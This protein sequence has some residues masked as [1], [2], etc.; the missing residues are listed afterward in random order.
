MDDLTLLEVLHA[1]ATAIADAL[2]ELEDWGLAGTTADQYR[3]DL[4]ACGPVALAG[5]NG[6]A[7]R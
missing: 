2:S 5:R 7:P 4:P 1:T 6:P 3:H